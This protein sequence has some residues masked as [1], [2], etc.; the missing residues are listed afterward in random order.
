MKLGKKEIDFKKAGALAILIPVFSG[1]LIYGEPL[2]KVA[3]VIF[4]FGSRYQELHAKIQN[5]DE[6][7]K[8]NTSH[9]KEFRSVWCI[10]RMTNSKKIDPHVLKTCTGW[11]KE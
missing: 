11:I 10:D 2:G 7:I 1:L 8:E 9:M 5:H 4:T 3:V 6:K